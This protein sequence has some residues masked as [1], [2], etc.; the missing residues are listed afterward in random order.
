MSR[1]ELPKFFATTNVNKL[2]EAREILGYSIEQIALE[3]DEPQDLNVV[4]V[5]NAKA[6]DAFRKT[7]KPVLVE[8]TALEFAAWRGLP[9]PLIKWFLASVGNAGLLKMLDGFDDRRAYARTV[10]A[11]FDG[12]GVHAFEG[13]VTGVVPITVCGTSG[14]G[15]DPIFIPDGHDK[16]FAQMSAAEKNAISM[17]RVAFTKMRDSFQRSLQ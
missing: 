10:V 9:G 3:L 5:V 11:F 4:M 6:I 2:R 15:W 7:G 16:S 17:R 13:M 1:V 14:F 8:D 12:K